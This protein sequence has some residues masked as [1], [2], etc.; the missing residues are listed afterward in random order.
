MRVT[1]FQIVRE[2]PQDTEAQ[3]HQAITWVVALTC[4][5]PAALRAAARRSDRPADPP[6]GGRPRGSRHHVPAS[7]PNRSALPGYCATPRLV[8]LPDQPAPAVV[9]ALR[10][11]HDRQAARGELL[12]YAASRCWY[13]LPNVRPLAS[14]S[15]SAVLSAARTRWS[16]RCDSPRGSDSSARVAASSTATESA[17]SLARPRGN[18]RWEVRGW[19]DGG[20]CWLIPAPKAADSR[21]SRAASGRERSEPALDCR[22]PVAYSLQLSQHTLRPDSPVTR[23]TS[24]PT[25]PPAACRQS[26]GFGP[27]HP[28]SR[29]SCSRPSVGVRDQAAGGRARGAGIGTSGCR[30]PNCRARPRRRLPAARPPDSAHHTLRVGPVAP[31]PALESGIRLRAAGRGEP[32]SGGHGVAGRNAE[33]DPAA[34]CLPPVPRIRTPDASGSQPAAPAL[35]P[36]PGSALGLRAEPAL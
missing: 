28:A 19:L 34:G 5:H 4:L 22:L 12:A 26:H 18:L 20:V 15:R 36:A 27:P 24:S 1:R 35:R 17:S 14:D 11:R 10:R 6:D 23:G 25:P 3:R 33:P 2:I 8:T 7:M 32:G 16:L 29:P 31:A 21:L 13:R 30:R 9:L